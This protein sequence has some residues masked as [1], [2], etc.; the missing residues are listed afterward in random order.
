MIRRLHGIAGGLALA[1]IL[2]FWLST[3]ASEL[4]GL[5]GFIVSVKRAIP[6]GFLLLVPAIAA[7]GATGFRLGKGRRGPLIAAKRRRMPIIVL[8]GVC[9]L[10]PCALGLA[11][12]AGEGRIDGVFYAVQA[13]E[14]VAGAVNIAFMALNLRDGLR[15]RRRQA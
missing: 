12:L 1:I 14:L 15:L 5:P 3:V 7:A 13:I 2:T 6:W 9:V 11:Y 8:N 10:V 4:S